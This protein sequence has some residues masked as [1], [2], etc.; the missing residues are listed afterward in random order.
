MIGKSRINKIRITGKN[1]R[2][3]NGNIFWEKRFMNVGRMAEILLAEIKNEIFF[4][5]IESENVEK[6]F[7]CMHSDRL[8]YCLMAASEEQKNAPLFLRSKEAIL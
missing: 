6:Q 8:F 4:W 1:I 5:P 2:K 7:L 3:N